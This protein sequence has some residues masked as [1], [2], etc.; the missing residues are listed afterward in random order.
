MVK[1]KKITLYVLCALAM[2]FFVAGMSL[3]GVA[4]D[5]E[6]EL[7]V[8][9][10]VGQD[11]ALNVRAEI[12]E[13]DEARATF[14]WTGKEEYS[15]VVVGAKDTD[16]SFIFQY[17]GLSAQYL[18]K[19]VN[20]KVEYKT[21]AQDTYTEYK[22][23]DVSIKDVLDKYLAAS[24]EDLGI[25][26]LSYS[27]L[28]ILA[29][30]I[31]AYGKAA[32]EYLN[33][34][35]DIGTVTGESKVDFSDVDE[36]IT[37]VGD[38]DWKMGV[39]FDYNLQPT[40]KFTTEEENITATVNGSA[41]KLEKLD[42]NV[43]R[44]VYSDFNLLDVKSTY[45]FE[46]KSGDTVLGS[47]TCSLGAL[48]KKYQS[49]NLLTAA[50]KYGLSASKYAYTINNLSFIEKYQ[51]GNDDGVVSIL[52]D[53]NSA[54]TSQN[55]SKGTVTNTWNS[56]KDRYFPGIDGKM[57]DATQNLKDKYLAFAI[58]T[59]KAG[60]Y[61]LYMRTQYSLTK[62][63]D[64]SL[65][66]NVGGR[67]GEVAL[68][69][70]QYTSY[71]FKTVNSYE[72]GNYD[73]QINW[74]ITKIGT[75]S[76][77]AGVNNITVKGGA[78]LGNLDYFYVESA[79]VEHDMG[80][81]LYD[82]NDKAETLIEN[83]TIE[84]KRYGASVVES[85]DTK[86][87]GMYVRVPSETY[88]GFRDYPL[89]MTMLEDAGLEYAEGGV[90]TVSLD[91]DGYSI[92]L[93][94]VCPEVVNFIS[95][96]Y[97]AEKTYYVVN[98]GV[99]SDTAASGGTDAT[100]Y[101]Y[102]DN[103]GKI[104]TASSRIANGSE[105]SYRQALSG[106]AG[107]FVFKF[108]VTVAQ[109]GEYELH[110]L[111][112][113]VSVLALNGVFSVAVTQG[114]ETPVYESNQTEDVCLPCG[115]WGT[116]YSA[117]TWTNM[118]YWTDAKI[119]TITLEAGENEIRIMGAAQTIP[120]VDY[121][122]V[123]GATNL[124]D[125]NSVVNMRN[126]FGQSASVG[127]RVDTS[128][129]NAAV[130]EKDEKLSQLYYVENQVINITGLWMNIPD[131]RYSVDN[132]TYVQACKVPVTEDMISGLDYSVGGLQTATITY[133][134][135]CGE[136]TA[137]AAFVVKANNSQY[138]SKYIFPKNNTYTVA[139]DGT[140]TVYNGYFTGTNVYIQQDGTT[141][142][143]ANGA[144]GQNLENIK[145]NI[146]MFK[147]NVTVPSTGVYDLWARMSNT[148]VSQV[149]T[150]RYAVAYE[151]ETFEYK[152]FTNAAYVMDAN[153]RRF[154]T[155]TETFKSTA[156]WKN[157]FDFTLVK[158]GSIVLQEGDNEVRIKTT[159]TNQIP[160]VN[161]FMFVGDGYSFADKVFNMRDT[162]ITNAADDSNSTFTVKAGEKLCA[163]YGDKCIN[164]G[165]YMRITDY[166]EGASGKSCIMDIGITEEML[167][168]YTDEQMTDNVSD[169]TTVSAGTTLYAKAT[170]T[171]AKGTW[172]QNFTITVTE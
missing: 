98:D 33:M 41:A 70:L 57:F 132:K 10:N 123:K 156:T 155:N 93:K 26:E 81:R 161:C 31:L 44:I 29:K 167:T 113:H 116:P 121:F 46:V 1:L 15:S 67:D 49:V 94:V 53:D 139:D 153:Q 3:I 37:T 135:A 163:L 112:Q 62:P 160:N 140:E 124:L 97:Q 65:E 23:A 115:Q 63:T 51:V 150:L 56:K 59:E 148:G 145:N 166:K 122:Y 137:Q 120:N 158:L 108:S 151:G 87:L 101:Q 68:S 19:Q 50:Y 165:L 88:A 5:T 38:L 82:F 90:Q 76:L 6:K 75:L 119:A 24:A 136:W 100:T 105:G 77:E 78:Q 58:T 95:D 43:Y 84:L 138:V 118:F 142:T 20:V 66:I 129:A 71:S 152:P 89:T 169:Y 45:T 69:S 149:S 144:F 28:Q 109:A 110:G 146:F 74:C 4:A 114:D 11:I 172:T 47:A 127:T 21:N 103:E 106:Y 42:N 30:D 13:A 157:M 52:E 34:T 99:E 32:Q 164:T 72:S 130:L 168:F 18:A 60:N 12:S 92:E 107:K 162:K 159:D 128:L 9:L 86:W 170:F 96:N 154:S 61:N 73:N 7:S 2:V 102:V 16:G 36:Q 25:S 35:D 125:D 22:S 126:T 27:K 80:A 131:Y 48:A 117:H 83:N 133:S 55:S 79:D 64:L 14:S 54:S 111:L 134:N 147:L 39:R 143:V 141:D 85:V 8:N 104:Q 171:T 17:K 40:A 91:V